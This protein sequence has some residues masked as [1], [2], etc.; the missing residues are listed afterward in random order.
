MAGTVRAPER[1]R[2]RVIEA[3]AKEFSLKGYDGTTLSAVARRA[4]VSKQ[5]LSHHFRTK[6][7]LFETVHSEK[8]RP[9][10]HWSETLPDDPR[11]LIAARFRKRA[12]NVDYMRF[13]AWEAAS[14]S[15]RTVPREKDRQKSVSEY[16]A[17]IRKMQRDGHL[18]ADVD[19][20]MIQLA[21]FSLATYP[22]TFTQ[23]TRLVTGRAGTDPKFQR[24]W[25]AF[26]EWVGERLFATRR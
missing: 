1:T 17:A 15:N 4:K 20:R 5:L 8:F 2:R 22:L 6:E 7:N 21:T 13:L 25:A 16:G 12:G 26:L 11:H 23:I 9:A 3:A 24:D 18:P 10:A 19:Y 14:K